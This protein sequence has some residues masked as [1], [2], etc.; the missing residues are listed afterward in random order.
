MDFFFSDAESP[1]EDAHFIASISADDL[2]AFRSL[3][4]STNYQEI[5][6]AL[7]VCQTKLHRWGNANQVKFDPSK[8]AFYILHLQQ[9]DGAYFQILG[10]KFDSQ[11]KMEEMICEMAAK[12]SFKCIIS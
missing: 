12:C 3:P 5:H 6:A 11:L 7:E 2:N 9:N 1:I 8:E 4:T 10:V